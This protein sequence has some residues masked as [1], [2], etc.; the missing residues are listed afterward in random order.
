MISRN[1]DP[2]DDTGQEASEA[3]IESLYEALSP[4]RP[5]YAKV[6]ASE[7]IEDAV[8]DALEKI[9]LVAMQQA[10]DDIML[11]TEHPHGH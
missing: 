3:L 5:F 10:R 6:G 9:V 1:D 2:P 11:G 8:V 4:L 7:D